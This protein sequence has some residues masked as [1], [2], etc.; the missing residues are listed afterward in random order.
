MTGRFEGR[1][2]MLKKVSVMSNMKKRV[3]A[4]D[5][6][7]ILEKFFEEVVSHFSEVNGR[8]ESVDSIEKFVF[9][10]HSF[11]TKEELLQLWS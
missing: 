3:E 1:H 5:A 6:C 9:K 4:K 10:R 8:R 7:F 11:Y 2:M